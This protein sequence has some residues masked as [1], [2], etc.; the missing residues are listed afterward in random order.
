M[1][2]IHLRFRKAARRQVAVAAVL[3]G[4]GN[5]SFAGAAAGTEPRRELSTDR[6]DA[7]ESPFTVEPGH[8]QLEMDFAHVTR[9]RENGVRTVEWEA[10]PFNL[11]FGLTRD[12]EAGVFIVP[13]RRVRT[14]PRTGPRETSSGFG[15]AGLRAKYNFHGNDGGGSAS[16][17]IV[18]VKVPSGARALSNRKW[19]GAVTLPVAFELGQELSLGA[20]TSAELV[21]TDEDRYRRA[22]SN[23]V[24]LARDLTKNAGAFVELTSSTGVGRHVATFDCGLTYALDRSTQLDAGV[25][26]GLSRT[27]PDMVFFAGLSKRF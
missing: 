20:M 19:E 26:L 8:T 27:A 4:F 6:P 1:S 23:T 21:Y 25:N 5:L 12:L 17:L 14:T 18:D 9:N 13:Y 2:L 10:A 16:G 7:T 11:R 3:L 24:T 22:W 15:D